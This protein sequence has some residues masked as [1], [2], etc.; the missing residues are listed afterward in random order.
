MRELRVL[1]TGDSECRPLGEIVLRRFLGEMDRRGRGEMDRGG[2][3]DSLLIT[4]DSL[5]L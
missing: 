2:G 3:G 5:R 4:G 1:L